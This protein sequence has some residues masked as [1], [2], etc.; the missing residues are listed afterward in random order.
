MENVI[1]SNFM[2]DFGTAVAT[3]LEQLAP[4]TTVIIGVAALALIISVII[5]SLRGH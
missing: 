5:S 2:S 3:Y 1:P 4:Y